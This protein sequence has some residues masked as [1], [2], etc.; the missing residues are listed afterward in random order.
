MAS[1]RLTIDLGAIAANWRALDAM[2]A[3]ETGAV[4]K[5]DGYGLGAARV[6][7][8][9]AAAGA[10]T[11]FVALAEE[12]AALRAALGARP[13]IFV[14][15]GLMP[16]DEPLIRDARLIPLLN[17]P[18]QLARA[19]DMAAAGGAPLEV[20]FQVDSGMNRLGFEAPELSDA[21]AAPDAL[22][23]LDVALVMSHLAC[24]DEPAEG[25]NGAQN[26]AF[27]ALASHPALAAAPKSLAA[28]G[29]VLLGPAYHHDLTRPGIGLYGGLPFR[30]ARPVV[31]LEAPII[32]VRD[33]APGEIVGYGATYKA[34]TARRVATL[35]LGYADGFLR[36]LGAGFAAHLGRTP[37]RSV[38][39]VSM[40]LVTLD[41]TGCAD[42]KEGALVTLLGPDQTI[43]DLADAA[44]TIGYEILTSL[45]SRFERRYRDA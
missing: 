24:A 4:V 27:L 44:G 13:R 21:L 20:G 19:R 7:P 29:G 40:D 10:K 2:S 39:R 14:F 16:G 31:M 32:Q 36:C 12:G 38:G 45:G 41:V 25:L 3:C 35:A 9:L 18:A 34:E 43:D 42:A 15:S 28:T 6:A 37:L 17:A 1:A 22:K 8:A 23:G 11:F 30:G 26:A 33:V 5:A